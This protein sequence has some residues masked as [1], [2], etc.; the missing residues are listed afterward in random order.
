LTDYCYPNPKESLFNPGCFLPAFDPVLAL[1]DNV[2]E[3]IFQLRSH[4]IAKTNRDELGVTEMS[5]YIAWVGI[6]GTNEA[7][8]YRVD[9]RDPRTPYSSSEDCNTLMYVPRTAI[10]AWSEEGQKRSKFFF[11]TEYD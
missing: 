8:L 9:E 11:V 1:Y 10:E 2:T 3:P 6:K 5:G 7:G 4:V